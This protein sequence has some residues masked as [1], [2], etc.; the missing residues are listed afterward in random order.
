L[1]GGCGGLAIQSE[2]SALMNVW[3]RQPKPLSN[4]AAPRR[5]PPANKSASALRPFTN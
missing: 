4:T 3:C 1:I 2:A 5:S